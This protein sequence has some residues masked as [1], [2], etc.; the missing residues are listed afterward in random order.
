MRKASLENKYCSA[1]STS[2]TSAI[3]TVQPEQVEAISHNYLKLKVPGSV[4]V[5][6]VKGFD[7][8]AKAI[9]P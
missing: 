5:I 3:L 4:G 1:L 8:G 7:L 6:V 9:L 2:L